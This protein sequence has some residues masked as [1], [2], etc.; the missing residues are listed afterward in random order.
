MSSLDP[1]EHLEPPATQELPLSHITQNLSPP[2]TSSK[3]G[4]KERRDPSV[5]PRKFNKFFNPR[6]YGTFP[7]TRARKVLNDITAPALNRNTQSSPIRPFPNLS[8]QESIGFTPQSKRRKVHH[9]PETSS[10]KEYDFDGAH[11]GI[12]V[13]GDIMSSPCERAVKDLGY[14]EEEEEEEE[15]S[16]ED[17]ELPRQEPLKRIVRLQDRGFGGQLLNR[18]IGTSM[19]QRYEY[20]VNGLCSTPFLRKAVLTST[21]WRDHTA[22]F[23]SKPE[24]V[25]MSMSLQQSRDGHRT[26]PFCARGLNSKCTNSTF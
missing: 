17:E 4:I 10:E 6:S 22:G 11:N 26:I 14:I 25:H 20:P 3:R 13:M 9:T 15:Y 18:S 1:K 23:Y 2:R 24:D 19:R 21:D 7:N 5:T 12:S 8:G 16:E